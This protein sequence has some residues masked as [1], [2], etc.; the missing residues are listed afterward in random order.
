VFEPTEAVIVADQCPFLNEH[1]YEKLTHAAYIFFERYF[2]FRLHDG[3]IPPA[4]NA[5]EGQAQPNADFG[6]T[7]DKGESKQK[8]DVTDVDF[9]EVK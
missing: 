7:Q 3:K 6:G 9:E 1:G 5:Q 4:D 2:R 8:G